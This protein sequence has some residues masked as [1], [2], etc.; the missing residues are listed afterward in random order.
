ML[1]SHVETAPVKALTKDTYRQAIAQARPKP[2]PD[3][4]IED[5]RLRS[6]N[7]IAELMRELDR[8]QT[9]ART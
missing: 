1:T 3:L 4:E 5:R 2:G 8:T 9:E 6:V 7:D